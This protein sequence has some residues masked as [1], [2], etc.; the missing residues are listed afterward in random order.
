[1]I[2]VITKFNISI[3]EKCIWVFLILIQN[4]N[5]F[6]VS[7]I[8]LLIINSVFCFFMSKYYC[9][10][11][12]SRDIIEYETFIECPQCRLE[13]EKEF[14]GVVDDENILARQEIMGFMDS[15]DE[16]DEDEF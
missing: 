12:K 8:I 11:C 13:F 4:E 14:F 6:K 7:L 5:Y 9:P 15:F 3:G 16:N 1:M 10:R 2:I